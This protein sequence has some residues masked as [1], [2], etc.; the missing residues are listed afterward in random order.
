M[1]RLTLLTALLAMGA[2][3]ASPA[4]AAASSCTTSTIATPNLAGL[5]GAHDQMTGRCTPTIPGGYNMVLNMQ[6]EQGG[7]WH[8]DDPNATLTGIA[9]GV[10]ATLDNVWTMPNPNCAWNWRGRGQWLDSTGG[11]IV[12]LFSQTLH[13]TC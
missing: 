12:S 3:F 9:P 1:K 6:Y 11:V 8:A 10:L 2:I 13:K 7:T 5:I 4:S